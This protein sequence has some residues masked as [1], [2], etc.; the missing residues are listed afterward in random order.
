MH[1]EMIRTNLTLG[2]GGGYMKFLEEARGG[3]QFCNCC[4]S[5]AATVIVATVKEN[6]VSEASLREDFFRLC[7][8]SGLQQPD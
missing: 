3:G 2:D 7:K 5:L 1:F 6:F 8:Y 4:S